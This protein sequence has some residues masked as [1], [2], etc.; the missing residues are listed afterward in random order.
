MLAGV[1]SQAWM[2][3]RTAG[4][5]RAG[6]RLPSPQAC[7]P[8]IVLSLRSCGNLINF[9]PLQTVT[10]EE[11]YPVRCAKHR[12]A[13]LIRVKQHYRRTVRSI[14]LVIGVTQATINHLDQHSAIFCV[15]TFDAAYIK[16]YI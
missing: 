2:R 7:L 14:I 8:L 9:L 6:Y 1:R 11:Q 13:L 5:S 3:V 16:I 15:N 12:V 10:W 4:A